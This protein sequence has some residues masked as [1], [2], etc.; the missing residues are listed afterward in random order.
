[1]CVHTLI[2]PIAMYNKARV[3]LQFQRGERK[4]EVGREGKK[5]IKVKEEKSFSV[6]Q[7]KLF[8]VQVHS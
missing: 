8:L 7:L 2:I 3:V 6:K 5:E 4:A 1:M